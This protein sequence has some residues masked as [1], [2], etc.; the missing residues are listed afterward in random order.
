MHPE[1][2]A[3]FPLSRMRVVDRSVSGPQVLAP[4]AKTVP[5]GRNTAGPT[6]YDAAVEPPQESHNCASVLPAVAHAPVDGV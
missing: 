6:S 5:S 3:N 4:V 1:S 2:P